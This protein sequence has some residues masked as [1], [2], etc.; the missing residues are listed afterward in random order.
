MDSPFSL[1]RR[2]LVAHLKVSAIAAA[3]GLG[4]YTAVHALIAVLQW[5]GVS[6]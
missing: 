4:A 1:Y 3:F 2:R 5:L 6:S